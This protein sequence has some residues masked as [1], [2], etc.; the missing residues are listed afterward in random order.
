M[1]RIGRITFAAVI[2]AGLAAM[3]D[4]RSSGQDKEPAKKE[5]TKQ[6]EKKQDEK[7]PDEKKQDEKKKEQQK[8]AVKAVAGMI[9]GGAQPQDE[10]AIVK[11]VEQQYAARFRQLYR[12]ELHFMRTVTEP[13][14]PQFEKIAAE[15][16]PSQKAAIQAFARAMR[17]AGNG[18]DEPRRP[19]TD[20]IA[21]SV[22]ANL[23]AEQSARY[24]KELDQR[25]AAR[26]RVMVTNVV[27]LMDRL[28]IL[29]PEQRDQLAKILTDNYDE[30][31][32]LMV[33]MYGGTYLPAIPEGKIRPVLTVD[34]C[35][36][37]QNA[38]N[39]N[40]RFGAGANLNF[41][42]QADIDDEV[43]DADPP[44]KTTEGAADKPSPPAEKP[45]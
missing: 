18:D 9:R 44:K 17:G 40:V 45:G 10:D 37:W 26:K 20:A 27:A 21:K 25:T 31:W 32:Q 30:S 41:V 1:R 43:W 15:T 33:F 24:Q 39:R 7:K 35:Q 38:G 28:L 2:A 36:V 4:G 14:R 6:A 23:T 42:Q 5:E 11:K 8:A 19:M 34:Q 3:G 13:T 22:K 29:R 16:E 12:T